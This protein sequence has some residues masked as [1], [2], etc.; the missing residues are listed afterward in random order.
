MPRM[1][2]DTGSRDKSLDIESIGSRRER[3]NR[4]LE[5]NTRSEFVITGIDIAAKIIPMAT[6]R[7][8]SISVNPV[9]FVARFSGYYRVVFSGPNVVSSISLR[10]RRVANLATQ[11][12]KCRNSAIPPRFVII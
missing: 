7:I 8:S 2:A 10:I 4:G 5:V 11:G 6:T 12:E 1:Q 9:F 3:R